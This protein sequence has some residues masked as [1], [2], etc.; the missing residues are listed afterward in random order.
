MNLFEVP[1]KNP[2]LL[3]DPL[4]RGGASFIFFEN[5][6]LPLFGCIF[7]EIPL[8]FCYLVSLAYS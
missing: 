6:G 2:G 7:S 1:K 3:Y 5:L 8:Q 4:N